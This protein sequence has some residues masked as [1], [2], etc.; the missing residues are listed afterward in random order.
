MTR[1]AAMF[2][3]AR[4]SLPVAAAREKPENLFLHRIPDF[5]P[6]S[7]TEQ[8]IIQLRRPPTRPQIAPDLIWLIKLFLLNYGFFFWHFDGTW[9][10]PSWRC[11]RP[12]DCESERDPA[13]VDRDDKELED[14]DQVDVQGV[15][16]S[17]ERPDDGDGEDGG[18]HDC[19]VWELQQLI[20][21][22]V[23]CLNFELSSVFQKFLIDPVVLVDR[24]SEVGFVELASLACFSD[25]CVVLLTIETPAT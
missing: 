20:L 22:K 19:P 16:D 4:G 24:A 25:H 7:V 17:G 15:G 14:G 23:P 21:Q 9:N 1:V 11:G 18:A 13:R 12:T 8:V 3:A 2:P 6:P 5:K 10:D